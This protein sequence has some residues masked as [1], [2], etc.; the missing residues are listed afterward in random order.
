MRSK[1]SIFSEAAQHKSL[2][3][4]QRDVSS[5]TFF[6]LIHTST[7][8]KQEFLLKGSVSIDYLLSH[9]SDFVFIINKFYYEG[10][11]YFKRIMGNEISGSHS[12]R[13]EYCS[14]ITS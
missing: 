3:W 8:W 7:C 6:S 10:R 13:N 1:I 11:T 14:Q 4:K 9:G 12:G 2:P 5:K